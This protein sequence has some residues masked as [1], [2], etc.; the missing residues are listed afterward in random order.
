VRCDDVGW[1][2][3]Y[4]HGQH[5]IAER[6]HSRQGFLAA[7]AAGM[8]GFGSVLKTKVLMAKRALKGKKVKDAAAF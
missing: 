8:T 7:A 4:T 5:A 1:E 6:T 3:V 2:F